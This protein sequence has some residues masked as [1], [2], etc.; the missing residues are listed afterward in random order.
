MQS[1]WQD[2]RYGVRMLLK[3][4]GFTIA[5]ILTLA[6]G[7]GV[8]TAIFSVVNGVLLRSLPYTEPDRLVLIN[9]SFDQAGVRTPNV[10]APAN[11]LDWRA[12]SH[13]FSDMAYYTFT[14]TARNLTGSG[15]PQK[16]EAMYVSDNLFQLLGA[17]PLL[18]RSFH[19]GEAQL[20]S[21]SGAVLS[22]R[23]WQRQFSGDPGIVGKNLKLD[24]GD[25][26]VIGVMPAAFEFPDPKVD[27]WLAHVLGP[28]VSGTRQ[29][30]FLHGVGRLKQGITVE[31]AD[32][33]LVAIAGRLRAQYPESNRNVSALVT[34]LRESEVGD[35]RR[36]LLVLMAA[37]GFVLLISCANVANLLL[38]QAASR[39]KEMAL[40]MALGARRW[41]IVRQLLTEMIALAGSGGVLGLL[42]AL[43]GVK[44]LVSLMPDTIAQAK[45]ATVD[46]HVLIFAL[47][48]SLL[49]GLLFG[50][51]PALHSSRP[52]LN[53][54]LKEGAGSGVGPARQRLRG[55][56]VVAETALAIILLTG[57]GLLLRSFVRMSSIDPGFRTDHL[58][59]FEVPLPF[60]KYPDTAKRAAF[61]DDL[62]QRLKALPGIESASATTIAPLKRW[63]GSMTWVTEQK[64]APKVVG[65]L[66][67]VTNAGLFQTLG[68]P[69]L[70]GRVFNEG[71]RA[72]TPGVVIISKSLAQAA[73]PGEDPIGKRMKM[74]IETN[75]WLTVVGVVGDARTLLTLKSY[76]I[77]YLSYTQSQ[78]FPPQD[79]VVRTTGDPSTLAPAIRGAVRAIDPDQPVANLQTMNQVISTANARP[80]FNLLVMGV[81]AALAFVLAAIGIY[82]VMAYTVA[83]YTREIGIR[84]ALGA[85]PGDVLKLIVGQGLVLALIGIAIGVAGAFGLTRLMKSLLFE[86]TA[87]DPLT[88]VCVSMLLLVIAVLACYL[89]ARRATKIDPVIALRY[90]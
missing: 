54:A 38:A 21:S 90:E 68:V 60:A 43:W 49:T 16:L 88:F 80:R 12:A 32:G 3:R 77:V 24:G 76:Q 58:L 47:A 63:G 7:V 5:A 20:D 37:A 14:T 28:Q 1:M 57:A 11:Y 8:N 69:L 27:L 18:G 15:E 17:A 84:M 30:H 56:L 59:T 82:G 66:P 39:Q 22:Y 48:V 72:D 87:T 71:D 64:D 33:E 86:V 9:E 40:R 2:L 81:F 79:V 41:R 34:S 23:L 70:R 42:L 29:A 13:S 6:L 51:V 65:A 35:I 10:I 50:L 83:Q 25:V 36:P 78:A 74:G 46:V 89:P 55:L 53:E 4:P 19:A 85:Q 52:D 67:R 31:Q 26:A 62:T 61:F 45:S 44:F 75:P 73:W